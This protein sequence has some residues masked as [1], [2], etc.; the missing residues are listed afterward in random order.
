MTHVSDFL[1]E[2]LAFVEVNF[3]VSFSA[4]LQIC[5]QVL[6]VVIDGLVWVVSKS[7]NQTV[8]LNNANTVYPLEL[9]DHFCLECF[10]GWCDTHG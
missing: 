8:I 3:Y 7:F 4:Y 1:C 6:V 10:A 2:E 5:L 9:F